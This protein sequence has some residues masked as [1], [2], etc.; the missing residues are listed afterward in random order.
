MGPI[1]S[2]I[3]DDNL[4]YRV[5]RIPGINGDHCPVESAVHGSMRIIFPVGLCLGSMRIISPVG[6]IVPG[7]NDDHLPD[8]VDCT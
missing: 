5:G 2:G 7:I 1:L 4:C 6:P 3:H 8:G